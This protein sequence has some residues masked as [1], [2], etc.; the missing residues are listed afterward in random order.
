MLEKRPERRISARMALKDPWL[1]ANLQIN[2][3]LLPMPISP[4]A[5]L[6]NFHAERRLQNAVLAFIGTN[7]MSKEDSRKMYDNFKKIDKNGDGKLSK[8]ELLEEYMKIMKKNE[9]VEEVSH[10]M[11][12]VDTNNSG[13]I[14]YSEFITAC[15]KRNHL[16]NNQSL[17]IAFKSFD[18]DGSGK[19]T[20]EELKNILGVTVEYSDDIMKGL[21][22]Q[23]DQ[24]GDGVI[25]LNEFKEMML[26]YFDNN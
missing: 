26:N 7:L 22:N 23:A 24:N 3:P 16:L 6:R 12:L 9:A 21:I 8:G 18:I 19:I 20:A 15:V 17:D 1:I 14:D 13:F 4:L 11:E 2:E 25:D 5:N 10:I